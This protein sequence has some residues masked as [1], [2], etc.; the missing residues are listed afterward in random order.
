MPMMPDVPSQRPPHLRI[1]LDDEGTVIS[2]EKLVQDKWELCEPWVPLAANPITDKVVGN[3][4]IS[5][6]TTEDAKGVR[7]TCTHQYCRRVC[8]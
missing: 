7:A 4:V 3:T 5:L 1:L 8:K 2:V 6:I